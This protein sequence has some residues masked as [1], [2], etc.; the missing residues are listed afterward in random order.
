LDS[1][2]AETEEGMTISKIRQLDPSFVKEVWAEEVK[3]N[4]VPKLL[5]AHF[6]VNFLLFYYQYYYCY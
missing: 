2:S 5:K 4:L 1:F 3:L 6:L